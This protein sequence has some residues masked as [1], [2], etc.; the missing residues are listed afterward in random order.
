MPVNRQRTQLSDDFAAIDLQQMQQARRYTDWIAGQIRP[1]CGRRVLEVGAG[2]GNITRR[3]LGHAEYVSSSAE[4]RASAPYPTDACRMALGSSGRRVRRAE[5]FDTIACVNVLEHVEA[6][7]ETL[8]RFRE[9]LHRSAGRLLLV[10]PAVPAAYGAID[11]ALGHYRRYSRRH[12]RSI[13]LDAG[14]SIDSLHYSNLIGLIAWFFNARIAR[15]VQQSDSQIKVFDRFIVPWSSQLE[16]LVPPPIGQSLV[17]AAHGPLN[18]WLNL[19]SRS[20]FP[21]TTRRPRSERSSRFP[22]SRRYLR[23]R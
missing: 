2:I 19:A 7:V 9:M 11:A 23:H 18:S 22:P 1:H 15:R 17:A 10:V 12:L 13:L 5:R 6:E 14:F 8:K 3:L 4:P 20:S 21:V 16:R